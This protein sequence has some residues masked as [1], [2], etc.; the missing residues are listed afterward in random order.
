MMRPSRLPP[1][2][3]RQE[4]RLPGG[5]LVVCQLWL[6]P[7]LLL[8]L[9][10]SSNTHNNAADAAADQQQD[11]Y[12][13][14]FL[15]ACTN[16]EMDVIEIALTEDPHYVHQKSKMGESCLH[17]AGIKGQT[18]VTQRL[19]LAGA[20]PNVRSDYE[21][22]LRMHPLSWN[23][24]GGH[25]E[26]A[27]ALLQGGADVNLDIDHMIRPTEKVT[28]LDLVLA[29]LQGYDED[30]DE[31]KYKQQQEDS[32]IGKHFRM[33]DLLLEFGA[34]RYK[35]LVMV[36]DNDTTTSSTNGNTNSDKEDL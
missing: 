24:Y 1:T 34:K 15:H 27:R 16:G 10:V 2:T 23:V 3:R 6:L 32:A 31:E 29:M 33:R 8:L 28:V 7:L 11:E 26:T 9:L 13:D 19:L 12:F 4:R 22:G 5:G 35:D 20:D 14:N 18:A 21:H 36:N 17:V 30:G 25:V